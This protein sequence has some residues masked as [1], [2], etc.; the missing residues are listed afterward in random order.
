MRKILIIVFS[1]LTVCVELS[2]EDFFLNGKSY[3]VK[4]LRVY[5]EDSHKMSNMDLK[6]LSENGFDY[7][8]WRK[9][10]LYRNLGIVSLSLGATFALSSNYFER[11]FQFGD[12]AW[13]LG[14][15]FL[16]IGAFTLSETYVEAN[17]L[18]N[19]L[20]D[21]AKI[22]ISQNGLSLIIALQ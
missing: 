8:S 2:A 17:K 9:L 20:N 14:S 22:A 21:R 7:E 1:L 18:I 19:I 4:G 12:N 13:R 3:S 11:Q 5:D 10:K 16:V 6:F 15:V